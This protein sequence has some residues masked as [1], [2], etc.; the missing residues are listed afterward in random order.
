MRIINPPPLVPTPLRGQP[1]RRGS[2]VLIVLAILSV[3]VLMAATLA[4]TSRLE[5][6][7]SQNFG[8]SIQNRMS[9]AAGAE[10]AAQQLAG[11]LPEG[12]VSSA[13][14]L[15]TF[16]SQPTSKLTSDG[17][18]ETAS[19]QNVRLS[20]P[21]HPGIR[22]PSAYFRVHDLSGRLNLNTAD[23]EQL[24]S[25]F[26]AISRQ[27]GVAVDSPVLADRIVAWR[28]GPD[29]QP[30][31]SSRPGAT[32]TATER[33]NTTETR[34]D[35]LQARLAATCLG[36]TPQ[37][38]EA[39]ARI[40]TG[41]AS[42]TAEF[43]PDI[44][45]PAFGDDR[46]FQ[47]LSELKQIEGVTPALL[48]AIAPH[49]TVFSIAQEWH[50]AAEGNEEAGRP[51]VDINHAT[52]E[53][54]YEALAEEYRG[55][56][57]DLL[58]RQFAV[59]IVDARRPGHVP[60][61]MS[62]GTGGGIVLG[63]A[64]APVITEVFPKPPNPAGHGSGG[65]YVEIHNP[66]DDRFSLSGWA[67]RVGSTR[68]SLH[69]D[70][71]P[72]GYLIVTDDFDKSGTPTSEEDYEGYGS[73]YDLFRRTPNQ[74]NR[75]LIEDQRLHLPDYP[76]WHKVDLEDPSGELVDRFA[77]TMTPQHSVLNSFQR[78]NPVVREAHAA[79]ATPFASLPARGSTS[80]DLARLAAYPQDVPFTSVLELFD[81]FAGF[82]K[83]DG[84]PGARWSWPEV[85]GPGSRS[86]TAQTIVNDPTRL[87]ARI[88]DI[89]TVEPAERPTPAG[90]VETWT[91]GRN[92][93]RLDSAPDPWNDRE[94]FGSLQVAALGANMPQRMY[95]R[96]LEALAWTRFA[97]PPAGLRH[98]LVNINTASYPVLR[99]AGFSDPQAARLLERRR[100]LEQEVLLGRRTRSV[101][102]E[103]LSDVLVDEELWGGPAT[104]DPCARLR[105]FRSIHGRITVNSRAFLLDGHSLDPEA[106][107]ADAGRGGTRLQAI[108]ALDRPKPEI[109]SWIYGP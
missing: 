67:V 74:S 7:S 11:N 97:P 96:Q 6:L 9:I 43:V 90:L 56:K 46:R 29:G 88:V 101:I 83:A 24:E 27:Y 52:A 2:A 68:V 3:L 103:K 8:Q 49:V 28:L 50:R 59:N 12:A 48:E 66:W 109:V 17:R 70:L 76:G 5:V 31:L 69:G 25:F 105:Q 107:P 100:T 102:Y 65:Q 64:R 38:L 99:S 39:I 18:E 55:T 1:R 57:D 4:Y 32:R 40:N 19:R 104:N 85:A 94:V 82:A 45:Q 62:D 106:N 80:R 41:A 63:V 54:I 51:L 73:F 95:N 58:L 33:Y 16:P 60:T 37:R 108:T 42:E 92:S 21:R 98:G 78:V 35:P 30:G 36:N 89:F 53:E 75:R 34:R 23:R 86:Q 26:N 72:R 14:L 93:E 91:A 79:R 10:N 81:V 13:D 87:D 71:P 47:A 20:G 44:R 84:Q 15:L 61:Q 77:Y 22:T